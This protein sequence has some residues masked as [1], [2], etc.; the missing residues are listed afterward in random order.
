MAHL[1][2]KGSIYLTI[3]CQVT[4]GGTV[5]DNKGINLP[6]SPVSLPALTA[7]DRKDA[8]FA[9]EQG[10]DFLCLSFVRSVDNI[11]QLRRL[12]LREKA[13]AGIIAKI[14]TPQ[15]LEDIGAIIGESDAIMIARGD[16]GV[17]LAPE[18]VPIVQLQLIDEARAHDRPVI[19]ATQVLES[20]IGNASPTRA[21]S[22]DISYAVTS[23]TDALMLSAETSVGKHPIEAVRYMDRAIRETESYRWKSGDFGSFGLERKR[24]G[25]FTDA[26]ANATSGLSRDL[27][28]R[29]IVVFSDSGITAR[30][31]SAARPAA[32]I[33][34]ITAQAGVQRR[35]MLNWGAI[36][37]LAS[38]KKLADPGTLARKTVKQLKLAKRGDAILLVQGER[39][40]NS[41]GS[42]SITA[43]KV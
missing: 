30:T 35:M 36:P 9:L 39:V 13:D 31:I 26:I 20:M 24:S 22:S 8:R 12:I 27:L 2:R 40:E 42:L 23:G 19:V 5:S 33:I 10:V 25:I 29:A 38:R 28:V 6:D 15:A 4:A 1:Y 43:M 37:L 17:E 7:K 34:C 41:L 16:L 3:H 18:K 14:E 11:R 32:P 21:E